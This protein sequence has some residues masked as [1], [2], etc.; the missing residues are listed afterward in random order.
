M[1]AYSFS[2]R[3]ETAR[4]FRLDQSR[5]S[6]VVKMPRRRLTVHP[7]YWLAV[8]NMAHGP[9]AA[10]IHWARAFSRIGLR[11]LPGEHG[12]KIRALAFHSIELR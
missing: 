11:T 1:P 4:V 7:F 12:I 8:E 2:G 6:G 3:K 9:P 10:E 5:L